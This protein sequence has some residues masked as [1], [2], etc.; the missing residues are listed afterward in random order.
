MMETRSSVSIQAIKITME[1]DH[2]MEKLGNT[3]TDIIANSQTPKDMILCT[4]PKNDGLI[5]SICTI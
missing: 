5:L 2:L 4:E 1:I 3:S